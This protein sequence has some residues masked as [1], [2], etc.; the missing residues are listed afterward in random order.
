MSAD[1]M[2]NS[3]DRFLTR[4]EKERNSRIFDRLRS[5]RRVLRMPDLGSGFGL[6]QEALDFRR[7]ESARPTKNH[8]LGP[9]ELAKGDK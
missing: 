9:S 7:L 2:V 4:V 3:L 1:K 6:F 8:T 5:S